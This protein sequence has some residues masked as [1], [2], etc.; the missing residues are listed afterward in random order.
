[1]D[2]NSTKIV[3]CKKCNN[4]TMH[5]AEQYLVH[6]YDLGYEVEVPKWGWQC[7][8]CGNLNINYQGRDTI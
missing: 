5:H 8:Q 7:E 1:M 2:W 3:Y 4:N 6:R